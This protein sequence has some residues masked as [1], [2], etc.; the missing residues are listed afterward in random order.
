ME[1]LRKLAPRFMARYEAERARRSGYRDR[2]GGAGRPEFGRNRIRSR[3]PPQLFRRPLGQSRPESGQAGRDRPGRRPDLSRALRESGAVGQCVRERRPSAR[4]A[5]RVLSR[6]HARLSRGLL[7]CRAGRVRAGPA[8][9]PDPLRSAELLPEGLG[10]DAGRLRGVACV[11]LRFGSA[12][13]HEGRTH[14]HRERLRH[15]ARCDS[16]VG[17]RRR[18]A[19]GAGRGRHRTRGHGVLDVLVGLDR[20]SQGASSTC[21]TTWRTPS[22][23]TARTVL[24]LRAGDRCFSVPKLFF[25]Y[26]FGNSLTFPF[27]VGATTVLM[28]GRPE[29]G[30]VLDVIERFR[31]TVLF[32]LPTLYTALVPCRGMCAIAISARCACRSPQPRCFPRRSTPAGRRWSGHGPTEGLG[33]TEMLHIYL[34]NRPDDHRLGAAGAPVP[35]YEVKLVTPE[36]RPVH[37]GRGWRDARTGRQLR[38]VLLAKAGQDARDDARRRGSRPATGSSNGPATT[39]FRVGP[40]S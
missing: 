15:D 17:V 10:G 27:S 31:P 4:V 9:H 8:E 23:P 33:S 19:G 40:T 21:T 36:G 26:G 28:P 34:S 24:R 5:H 2:S 14:R 30:A 7:R 29:A 32:G 38:P 13:G 20:K 16:G 12:S 18:R 3:P 22:S 6:R 11:E 35:G 25:A 37:A 39:T 1:R